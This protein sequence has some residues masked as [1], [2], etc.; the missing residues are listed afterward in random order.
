M[1]KAKNLIVFF[2]PPKEEVNGGIMSIFSIARLSR[3]F[4]DIH[5]A[6]VLISV[7]PGYDSYNKNTLFKND[8]KI[9]SFDE[10]VRLGP[11]DTLQIHV[12][13]YASTGVLDGLKAYSGYLDGVANFSVN[14]MNQNIQHMRE[15]AEVAHWFEL[16][17]HV[18]QT[19]AHDRYSTQ[20]LADRYC[21]AT[22]HLSV[23]LDPNNYSRVDFNKKEKVILLS[24]DE[25]DQRSAIVKKLSADLPDYE[26]VTVKNMKYE[27]FKKLA[28]KAE[29][30]VTFGEGLDGYYI[31]VFFSGGVTFAVYNDDFFPDTDF[32]KFANNYSSYDE[33]LDK[34]VGDIK[35]LD[36]HAAYEKLVDANVDKLNRLYNFE[37]YKDNLKN[38]YLKKFTYLP[39]AASYKAMIHRLGTIAEETQYRAIE[40]DR[41][42][43]AVINERNERIIELEKQLYDKEIILHN[44]INS[45]SW[46]L[47]KPLRRKRK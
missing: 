4:K 29:F 43:Q 11:P 40:S 19:T 12:P 3:G 45:R 23:Y 30:G 37:K 16:T 7:Y 28:A 10:I 5:K 8:E 14:I 26:L 44:I 39:S 32:A 27:D 31:E 15:P 24:P 36:K 2:V 21:L 25:V 34:L 6:E 42:N 18:T 22:H 20:Q 38:F 35:R 46:K 1:S 33:M 13:E 47:T 9:Y 41:K 17:P